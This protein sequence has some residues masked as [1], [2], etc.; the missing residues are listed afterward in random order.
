MKYH[1][2]INKIR[3]KIASKPWPKYLHSLELNGIRGWSG[4]EIRFGFPVTVIT[5]ENGTGKSTILKAAACAYTHPQGK[6]NTYYP[7]AFFPDT[8]WENITGASIKYKIREANNDHIFVYRKRT[9]RWRPSG[10]KRKRNVIIQDVSRTLPLDATVGYAKIAKQSA[11][12]VSA[13]TLSNEITRYFS[14]IIGR[15]YSEAKFAISNVDAKREV[16]VVSLKNTEISQFH[17]GAGEDATLDLLS[18]F[19]EIPDTSLVIIDEVEASLHPR[20]QRRLVHFLLWLARTKQI[21]IIITTHSSYVLEELPPEARILIERKT[22]GIEIIYNISPN[23]ALNRMDDIDA[24]ELY[25]FTEDEE[26]GIL[27][28]TILQ[29]LG[30]DTTRLSFIDIG[31]SNVVNALASVTTN[32]RFPVRAIAMVDADINPQNGSIKLPGQYAPEKQVVLDIKEIATD[33]LALRL[34]LSESSIISAIDDTISMPD[35]HDWPS[36]LARLLGQTTSYIWQTLCNVW[37]KHCVD[38][39]DMQGIKDKVNE[40]LE[41]DV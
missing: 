25:I 11:N 40:S 9:E 12:E 41:I 2:E 7:S 32:E 38:M 36:N 8:P 18:L 5:G 10:K 28:K 29:H 19:Q 17:Q 22:S 3:S 16:G 13:K 30:I 6:K 21:Q 33:H 4:E 37:V 24:P 34:E 26:A 20:S 35:Y 39:D 31:P 23:F 15:E 1:Q 27:A 14:S